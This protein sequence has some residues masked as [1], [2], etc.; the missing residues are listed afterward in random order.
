[1]A[2]SEGLKPLASYLLQLIKANFIASGIPTG[3]LLMKMTIGTREFALSQ[4]YHK[5]LLRLKQN[6]Y[7]KA[8]EL[9]EHVYMDQQISNTDA[10]D[11]RSFWNLPMR[12]MAHTYFLLAYSG[13]K[14]HL[15]VC[16]PSKM[17]GYRYTNLTIIN[18]SELHSRDPNVFD[19]AV[20]AKLPLSPTD[21]VSHQSLRDAVHQQF[22]VEIQGQEPLVPSIAHLGVRKVTENGDLL[23][24]SP[25]WYETSTGE[26]LGRMTPPEYRMSQRQGSSDIATADEEEM[27]KEYSA[28]AGRR[29]NLPSTRRSIIKPRTI[30]HVY[31][32][33]DI[34]TDSSLNNSDTEE[35]GWESD[36][37]WKYY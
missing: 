24:I 11:S 33:A 27:Y 8:H 1:M 25:L 9:L 5:E 21:A 15:Q 12:A 6:D 10:S 36:R 34:S 28:Y 32:Y 16:K 31:I 29:G 13:N 20:I 19:N 14:G 30:K 26:M 18:E 23:N 3:N 2:V 17:S 4:K 37:S 22:Q 7:T 35:H